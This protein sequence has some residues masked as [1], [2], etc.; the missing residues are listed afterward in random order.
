MSNNSNDTQHQVASIDYTI[1]TAIDSPDRI[2]AIKQAIG[3]FTTETPKI[4]RHDISEKLGTQSSLTETEAEAILVGLLLNDVAKKADYESPFV[5]AT[6][7]ID[8]PNAV[9]ILHEQAAACSA[10][11]TVEPDEKLA[12][13]TPELVVTSP[14]DVE[15]ELPSHVSR[16]ATRIRGLL[17]EAEEEVRVANP[18]FDP[19]QQVIEEIARLPRRGIQTRVLTRDVTPETDRHTVLK[20][21]A[22]DL[23][24]SEQEFFEVAEFFSTDS[25]SG[26]QKYATH[27]KTVIVDD[28]KCYLGSANLTVTSL[29][30]NFEIGV[31][32]KGDQVRAVQQL[33]D[34][35]FEASTTVDL[36]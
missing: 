10:L 15:I 27:A 32:L 33:F 35:V 28:S 22:E 8:V 21:I 34:G 20:S 25:T 30:T 1:A 6:F 24:D 7:R 4:T 17:I 2:L 11:N 29:T 12:D 18:Y 26:T 5:D 23:A 14:P 31:L 3:G 16:I 9:K 13:S 36:T 19:G